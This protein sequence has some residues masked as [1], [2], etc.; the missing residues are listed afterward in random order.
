MNNIMAVSYISSL[1]LAGLVG[2]FLL[3]RLP[4][5]NPIYLTKQK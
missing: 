1:I 4:R 2:L 5:P 3:G